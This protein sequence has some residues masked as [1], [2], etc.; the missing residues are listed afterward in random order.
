MDGEWPLHEFFNGF[1]VKCSFVLLALLVLVVVSE[2]K[3]PGAVGSIP[4]AVGNMVAWLAEIAG[5]TASS[6][7]AWAFGSTRGLIGMISLE[8]CM[9]FAVQLHCLCVACVPSIWRAMRARSGQLND[10]TRQLANGTKD[11]E[12]IA[13][14]RKEAATKEAE[15]NLKHVAAVASVKEARRQEAARKE[16][17]KQAAAKKEADRKEAA[18]QAAAKKE[19]DRKEAAKKL[20][21]QRALAKKEMERKE[22]AKKLAEKK[23]ARAAATMQHRGICLNFVC[24]RRW[25]YSRKYPSYEH[26]CQSYHRR[27]SPTPSATR[28]LTCNAQR[29]RC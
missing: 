13:A 21:E 6:I 17:A 11:A 20:A 1:A 23:Q 25:C 12:K 4:G 19:A 22:A 8:R 3:Y 28:T 15:T 2:A 7:I 26:R 16:A 24:R 29:T 9:L 10:D 18:K 14:E 27:Q 5:K